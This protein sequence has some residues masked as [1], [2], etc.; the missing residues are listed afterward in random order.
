VPILGG[1]RPVGCVNSHGIH[2]VD[3]HIPQ[4]RDNVAACS[5][6]HLRIARYLDLVGRTHCRDAIA[7]YKNGLFAT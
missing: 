3:V 2:R 7:R 5:V 6:N 4:A 1:N